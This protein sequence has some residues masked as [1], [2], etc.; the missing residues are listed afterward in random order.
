MIVIDVLNYLVDES[1]KELNNLYELGKK[2]E[3]S[4][5]VHNCSSLLYIYT[6]EA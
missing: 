4:Y 6:Y 1:T 2:K 3:K 5:Y